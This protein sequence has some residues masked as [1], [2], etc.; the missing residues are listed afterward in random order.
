MALSLVAGTVVAI[1]LV[2]PFTV[3]GAQV[4]LVGVVVDEIDRGTG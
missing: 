4:V 2:R 1:K 3:T